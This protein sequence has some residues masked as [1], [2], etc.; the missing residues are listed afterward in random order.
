MEWDGFK[1]A[2][3]ALIALAVIGPISACEI[4]KNKERASLQKACIEAR[5]DW[6]GRGELGRCALPGRCA[7]PKPIN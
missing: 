3:V 4:R 1:L 2:C 5:G 6:E 7:F